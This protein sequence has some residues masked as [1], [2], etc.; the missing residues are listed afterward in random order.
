MLVPLHVSFPGKFIAGAF[1]A[2]LAD[3]LFDL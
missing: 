3:L 1:S 2:L